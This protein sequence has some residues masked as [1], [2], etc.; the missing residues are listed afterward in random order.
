MTPLLALLSFVSPR[1]QVMSWTKLIVSDLGILKASLPGL[2]EHVQLPHISIDSFW[3]LLVTYASEWKKIVA[4]YSTPFDDTALSS[5]SAMEAIAPPSVPP[6]VMPILPVACQSFRCRECSAPP[7][8]TLKALNQHARV[9]HGRTSA[10]ARSVPNIT[11]CPICFTNFHERIRLVNHLS[12]TRIRFVTRGTN[13]HF[14]FVKTPG[15]ILCPEAKLSPELAKEQNALLTNA[16]SQGHTH[17][18]AV[19]SAKKGLPSVLKGVRTKPY[20]LRRRI[21]T[22]TSLTILLA[23][24]PSSKSIR[25]APINPHLKPS[26]FSFR[27][28]CLWCRPAFQYRSHQCFLVALEEE[29]C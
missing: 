15:A 8:E 25:V 4:R 24:Y 23:L 22:K 5:G 12:D 17:V 19:K 13:C 2:L 18:L 6:P 26:F 14:W 3:K 27:K 7:F 21:S 11:I 29:T 20:H 1:G 28:R 16:R 10:I 9:K